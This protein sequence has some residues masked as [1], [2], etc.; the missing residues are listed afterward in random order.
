ME[1]YS[2][3]SSLLLQDAPSLDGSQSFASKT[4]FSSSRATEDDDDH[5]DEDHDEYR[6]RYVGPLEGMQ[7]IVSS[8]LHLAKKDRRLLDLFQQNADGA[9]HLTMT[10]DR[11]ANLLLDIHMDDR[12]HFVEV[13]KIAAIVQT[14][15]K[16]V[17]AATSQL[18]KKKTYRELRGTKTRVRYNSLGEKVIEKVELSEEVRDGGGGGALRQWQDYLRDY[19]LL[20]RS[21]LQSLRDELAQRRRRR[22]DKKRSSPR[23]LRALPSGVLALGVVSATLPENYLELPWSPEDAIYLEETRALAIARTLLDMRAS[24]QYEARPPDT[25]SSSSSTS[26]STQS[27]LPH[28]A[29][30]AAVPSIA[31]LLLKH[32]ERLY[33]QDVARGKAVAF[34]EACLQYT[35]LPLLRLLCYPLGLDRLSLAV[36][37]DLL[38]VRGLFGPRTYLDLFDTI[39]ALPDAQQVEEG[40]RQEEEEEEEEDNIDLDH[41]LETFY[42]CYMR[43][44]EQI[45]DLQHNIFGSSSSSSS[46]STAPG[47]ATSTRRT[48]T[49]SSRESL[50]GEGA[51]G[52]KVLLS[53]ELE[54]SS[55]LGPFHVSNLCFTLRLL[56]RCMRRDG[57]RTGQLPRREVEDELCG[58]VG[59][60]YLVVLQAAVRKTKVTTTEEVSYQKVSYID[61]VA[62]LLSCEQAVVQGEEDFRHGKSLAKA[63]QSLGRAIEVAQARELVKFFSMASA[64]DTDDD[65]HPPLWVLGQHYQT[66]VVAAAAGGGGG[67]AAGGGGG[68]LISRDGLWRRTVAVPEDQ[69]GLLTVQPLQPLPL[70]STQ[71]LPAEERK[72][73]GSEG[74]PPMPIYKKPPTSQPRQGPAAI[75]IVSMTLPSD[76]KTVT[77]IAAAGGGGGGGG[78][79]VV[80]RQSFSRAMERIEVLPLQEGL[81]G[82]LDEVVRGDDVSGLPSAML[83]QQ[84]EEASLDSNYQLYDLSAWMDQSESTASSQGRQLEGEGEGGGGGGGGGGDVLRSLTPFRETPPLLLLLPRQPSTAKAFASVSSSSEQSQ[85]EAEAEVLKRVQEAVQEEVR[86]AADYH[87]EQRLLL[88]RRQEKEALREQLR[89]EMEEKEREGLRVYREGLRQRSRRLQRAQARLKE[90]EEERLEE[91]AVRR[92]LET[93]RFRALSRLQKSAPG[94]QGSVLQDSLEGAEEEE[95][96]E[97][98][99]DWKSRLLEKVSKK[100]QEEEGEQQEEEEVLVAELSAPRTAPAP[101]PTL[102]FSSAMR[103]PSSPPDEDDLLGSL[104]VARVEQ[105]QEQEERRGSRKMSSASLLYRLRTEEDSQTEVVPSSEK[106]LSTEETEEEEEEQ[107]EEGEQ[108]EEEEGGAN[109]LL[110]F[111]FYD[112]VSSDRPLTIVERRIQQLLRGIRGGLASQRTHPRRPAPSAFFTPQLFANDICFPTFD[113]FADRR[114]I[115]E[116]I[117]EGDGKEQEVEQEEEEQE[118]EEQA[119]ARASFSDIDAAVK[120]YRRRMDEERMQLFKTQ[121][122]EVSAADWTVIMRTS[123]AD[124]KHFFTKQQ[125]KLDLIKAMARRAGVQG[126]SES[127]EED[128]AFF[129]H[130]G[131]ASSS[132]SVLPAASSAL[133]PSSSQLQRASVLSSLDELPLKQLPS[134][135]RQVVA[136]EAPV[137]LPFGHV[138]RLPV[139]SS[140]SPTS[141][142]TEQ[143]VFF[144]LEVVEERS[145]VTI[146]L[147]APPRRH[148]LLLLSSLPN[149]LPSTVKY[150]LKASCSEEN[151]GLVRLFTR[152]EQPGTYFAAV[153]S[154]S[155]Y[156][157]AEDYFEIWAYAAGEA[158]ME[159]SAAPSSSSAT[160]ASPLQRVSR[161]IDKFNLLSAHSLEELQVHFPRLEKEA[162]ALSETWAKQEEEVR[163][164]RR[165]VLREMRLV[166]QAGRL[167]EVLAKPSSSSFSAPSTLTSS[168]SNRQREE[169]QEEAENLES[170]VVK[171]GR[172]AMRKDITSSSSSYPD[173]EKQLKHQQEQEEDAI[174]QPA[175]SRPTTSTSRPS[176]SGSTSRPRSSL[177]FAKEDPNQHADLFP[178]PALHMR[179]SLNTLAPLQTLLK[180]QEEGEEEEGATAALKRLLE[181]EQREQRE[182]LRRRPSAYLSPSMSPVARK[183]DNVV[184]LLASNVVNL[185]EKQQQEEEK[186]KRRSAEAALASIESVSSSRTSSRTSSPVT[187]PRSQSLSRDISHIIPFSLAEARRQSQLSQLSQSSAGGGVGVGVGVGGGAGLLRRRQSKRLSSSLSSAALVSLQ[188]SSSRKASVLAARDAPTTLLHSATTPALQQQEQEEEVEEVENRLRA[189]ALAV[190]HHPH[191]FVDIHPVRYKLS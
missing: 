36:C 62:L 186:R 40:Q 69:P 170:F 132:S 56:R 47:T 183:L 149:K 50:P 80:E 91:Q 19:L 180:E 121:V 45:R 139:P 41:F 55:D 8:D 64:F 134:S 127:L 153:A 107:E 165:A 103:R 13:A 4:S 61:L 83:P 65:Q 178:A 119:G 34:L 71:L 143:L 28:K 43:K 76:A 123:R 2:Q 58:L 46:S 27:P 12:L 111:D 108:Q 177:L 3:R 171:V 44:D 35:H 184:A 16:K 77:P 105:E 1:E 100:Q 133:P 164:R 93:N 52:S 67:G 152:F 17:P 42:F 75:R 102:S 142:A 59:E 63:L 22:M 79:D 135:L 122:E 54:T 49:A 129:S 31:S 92:Q 161:V 37:D 141:T 173:A 174:L 20:H 150:S 33:G 106:T 68:G 14:A 155:S 57:L 130:T 113:S 187:S 86:L 84:V 23:R 87:D 85:L 176:T 147:R 185:P 179:R 163:R 98:D 72:G 99:E 131:T 21:A 126:G 158:G 70:Q 66:P 88:L 51:E 60:D 157:V 15:V 181:E 110:D 97:V 89:R 137:P 160:T 9:N 166:Q 191:L 154:S 7:R 136:Q 189:K 104:P 114:L 112:G 25:S 162:A 78:G 120:R 53:D 156:Q 146:E 128:D 48:E 90:E 118:E 11:V 73:R 124:W 74:M 32:L 138:L 29:V 30:A 182:T 159:S 38:R 6:R 81:G 10:A 115:V 39:Q 169:L 140:S 101:P 96:E 145:L 116:P 190:H 82:G 125:A 94:S 109:D 151:A 24:F 144:Q 188:T 168:S 167:D 5:H 18:N 26:T 172:M 95:E 175:S 148:L 117:S